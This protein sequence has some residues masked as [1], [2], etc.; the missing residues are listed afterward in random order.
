MR[1][2]TPVTGDD[3]RPAYRPTI[4]HPGR[5][6][7]RVSCY[8]PACQSAFGPDA[9]TVELVDR[10]IYFYCHRSRV[11]VDHLTLGLLGVAP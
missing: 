3:T 8:R 6:G 10:Q 7:Q 9:R 5:C 11:P 2:P 4:R 1:N